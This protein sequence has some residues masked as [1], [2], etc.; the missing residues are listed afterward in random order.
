MIV[1][2]AIA[3]AL[4]GRLH[5]TNLNLNQRFTART[6]HKCVYIIVHNCSSHY[7]CTV[8][9]KLPPLACYNFKKCEPI[10]I[11]LA[12]I[13]RGAT[14]F[15]KLGVQLLD[16]GYYTEQNTDGIPSFVHCSLQVRKKLGWSVQILGGSG[17]PPN[18]PV[19]APLEILQIK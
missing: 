19:D 5:A 10:L 2:I 16:L 15:S 3:Q 11:F 8:F 4:R 1:S 17:P 9:Q 14:T 7:T 6:V 12:E 13:L 18:P